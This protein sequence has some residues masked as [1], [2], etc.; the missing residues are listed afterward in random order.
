MIYLV[1]TLTGLVTGAG[2]GFGVGLS[3]AEIFR[4][5]AGSNSGG[6]E[7]AG[8][9]FIGP[10]GLIAGFLFGFG[11]VLRWGGGSLSGA[12]GTWIA[13]G[14]VLALGALMVLISLANSG[15]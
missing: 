7:M 5:V 9:F 14:I 6:S 13:G 4:R 8:F 1:A 15:R 11:A 2:L 10:F 12:N 3:A